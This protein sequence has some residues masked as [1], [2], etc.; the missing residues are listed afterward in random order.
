MESMREQISHSNAVKMF[1]QYNLSKET[2]IFF[3]EVYCHTKIFGLKKS[4]V[5]FFPTSDIRTAA[6]PYATGYKGTEISSDVMFIPTIYK[7]PIFSSTH[8]Q[9]YR[10]ITGPHIIDKEE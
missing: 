5:N 1:K 9:I 3:L 4:G 8:T 10:R 7:N 6:I 2:E